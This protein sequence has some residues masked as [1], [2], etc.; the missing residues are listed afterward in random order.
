[1]K[2]TNEQNRKVIRSTDN[3]NRLFRVLVGG[4]MKSLYY[5]SE[6]EEQNDRMRKKNSSNI[7]FPI[8]DVEQGYLHL[9]GISHKQLAKDYILRDLFLWSI[10]MNY[11][12]VAKVL[13]AHMKDRI[14]ATLIAMKILSYMRDNSA[15]AVHGD[16]KT[17]LAYWINYFEQYAIDCIDL[18]FKSDQNIAR[19]LTIQRVEMFGDVTCL[20][21][22]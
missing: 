4:D 7:I 20:Q 9:N 16:K 5:D 8:V 2:S 15:D 11:M 12:D 17:D 6:T 19:I 14:C 1:M 22:R 21:V 3:L 13:L 18:C 10:V